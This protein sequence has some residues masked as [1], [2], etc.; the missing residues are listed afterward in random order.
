MARDV[1]DSQT[2][3][4]TALDGI[5]AEGTDGHM[6]ISNGVGVTE[7]GSVLVATTVA[8]SIGGRTDERQARTI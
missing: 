2:I 5:M 8:G 3:L 4:A 6:A 7:H 1:K